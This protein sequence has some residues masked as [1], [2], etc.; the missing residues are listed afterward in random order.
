MSLTLVNCSDCGWRCQILKT[1]QKVFSFPF[2]FLDSLCSRLIWGVFLAVVCMQRTSS[3]CPTTLHQR[4]LWTTRA[5]TRC[6]CCGPRQPS[7]TVW[8]RGNLLSHTLS[9]QS[10]KRPC[11]FA[12]TGVEMVV[13]LW[14]Q[15]ALTLCRLAVTGMIAVRIHTYRLYV[16]VHQSWPAGGK[17][18]KQ[19][20]T[21]F[22]QHRER[23]W[24]L[25]LYI[26][27]SSQTKSKSRKVDEE[28]CGMWVPTSISMLALYFFV[29]PNMS[30]RPKNR[31]FMYRILL[32][33]LKFTLWL[34]KGSAMC[35]AAQPRC[36][37]LD[38]IKVM[39]ATWS[40]I[41]ASL[42]PTPQP[43]MIPVQFSLIWPE[44]WYPLRLAFKLS[45]NEKSQKQSQYYEWSCQNV[46]AASEIP[47]CGIRR[48]FCKCL[49]DTVCTQPNRQSVAEKALGVT[50]ILIIKILP[51]IRRLVFIVFNDE[52][53]KISG[54]A[55]QESKINKNIA[56]SKKQAHTCWQF[57]LQPKLQEMLSA[58]HKSD[59]SVG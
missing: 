1:S 41:S 13:I 15:V 34:S 16:N 29:A 38:F 27:N 47:L 4:C 30:V 11:E 20:P 48:V 2:L 58:E 10:A 26:K 51:V 31:L 56:R 53:S 32:S 45:T 6:S 39:P 5:S 37:R 40:A 21:P 42:L 28:S 24:I 50:T 55:W 57:A 59:C 12:F 7:T 54:L 33:V 43:V 36:M 9:T 19:L 17:I 22:P 23:Y 8:L 3:P 52:L 44:V 46:T 49:S 18:S 14:G 25:L 35:S